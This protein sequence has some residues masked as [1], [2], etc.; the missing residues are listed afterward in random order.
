[1]QVQ[2]DPESLSQVELC[3][4]TPS[5]HSS[6]RDL[7]KCYSLGNTGVLLTTQ[8]RLLLPHAKLPLMSQASPTILK[9]GGH[10]LVPRVP[11][12]K[13]NAETATRRNFGANMVMILENLL[14]CCRSCC[15]VSSRSDL[16]MNIYLC[17]TFLGYHAT[18]EGFDSDDSLSE[19]SA[20]ALN[21]VINAN[22]Q[23]RYRR[24]QPLRSFQLIFVT[25]LQTTQDGLSKRQSAVRARTRSSFV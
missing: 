14:D 12:A 24:L 23:V 20:R 19:R 5:M 6:C 18:R 9:F 8:L 10:T 3:C 17:L 1:M 15:L 22:E 25:I 21:V 13:R 7:S 16:Y 2:Y 4:Q 11:F